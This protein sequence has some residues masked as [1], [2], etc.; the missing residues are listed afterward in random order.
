MA[1]AGFSHLPWWS[2]LDGQL[3]KAVW[4]ALASWLKH[5]HMLEV[6]QLLDY[7]SSHDTAVPD[8]Q[9]VLAVGPY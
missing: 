9:P 7:R 2:S 6:E 8:S 1:G 3:L 4:T 5:G